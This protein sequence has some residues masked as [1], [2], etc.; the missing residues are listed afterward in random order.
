MAIISHFR[1]IFSNNP[2]YIW[3]NLANGGLDLVPD[4]W[5]SLLQRKGSSRIVK[6][7]LALVQ[8]KFSFSSLCWLYHQL[9]NKPYKHSFCNFSQVQMEQ[10]ERLNL[11]IVLGKLFCKSFQEFYAPFLLN[12]FLEHVP[13]LHICSFFLFPIRVPSFPV[14]LFRQS[15]YYFSQGRTP[16]FALSNW[17]FE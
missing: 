7:D 16:S 6:S 11:V 17:A 3:P 5:A 8:L 1:D 13:I 9:P 12:S 2:K 14:Y 15:G 4:S 10:M